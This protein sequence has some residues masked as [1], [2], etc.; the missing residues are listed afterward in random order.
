L[1]KED[2]IWIL[3]RYNGL[4]R[5]D[6]QTKKIDRFFSETGLKDQL[7]GITQD[8][9]GHIW[10]SATDE[11]YKLVGSVFQ[12]C[13]LKSSPG[14]KKNDIAISDLSVLNN[15]LWIATLD[16]GIIIKMQERIAIC[17]I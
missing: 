17:V 13:F 1:D 11:L 4:F 16:D 10:V 7:S 8:S 15:E 3:T 5:F 14:F 12:P 9:A 2:N 6:H